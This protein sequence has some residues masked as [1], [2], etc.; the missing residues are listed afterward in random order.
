MNDYINTDLAA[1]I[2]DPDGGANVAAKAERLRADGVQNANFQVIPPFPASGWDKRLACL[3]K[4]TFRTIS[5]HFTER[6]VDEVVGDVPPPVDPLADLADSDL[7]AAVD[8]AGCSNSIDT[9][10]S[11][12]DY[13]AD[14]ATAAPMPQKFASFRGLAKGYRFFS[15]LGIFKTSSIM[16]CLISLVTA[17]SVSLPCRPCRKI[18]NTKSGCAAQLLPVLLIT[19]QE[20]WLHS[21]LVQLAS[22]DAATMSVVFCMRL[23]TLYGVA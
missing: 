9:A 11:D 19:Y 6:K 21:V 23:M 10:G 17:T 20:C 4:F 8:A 2:V 12:D 22:Q 16:S 3:P 7:C 5:Q 18:V 13:Q 14:A 1:R 15:S